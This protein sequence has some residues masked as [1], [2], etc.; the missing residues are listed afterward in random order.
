MHYA[1]SSRALKRAGRSRGRRPSAI[2]K[3]QRCAIRVTYARNAVKGHWR[4]HGRYIARENAAG[5]STAVGFE[6]KQ[7]GVDV[8]STLERWQAAH[9]ARL[10]KIIIS[11]E[12][13]ER[14]DLTR[15]AREPD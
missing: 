14:L 8:V 4:A 2:P 6:Q 12:F 10:W 1:R 3:A 9:D 15:L 5:A 7:H 11:P 13:G